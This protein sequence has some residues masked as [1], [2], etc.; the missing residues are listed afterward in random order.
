MEKCRIDSYCLAVGKASC[1]KAVW[2]EGGASG[3]RTGL[4]L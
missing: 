2:G 4:L 3:V 1:V